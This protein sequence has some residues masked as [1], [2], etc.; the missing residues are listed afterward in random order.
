M[1]DRESRGA[2]IRIRKGQGS[3]QL[4]RDSFRERFRARFFD[5]AFDAAGPEIDRLEEIAWDAYDSSRKAPR[6]RAAGP[7]FADPTY[8][9]SDEWRSAREAI[10]R[11]AREQADP[12]SASRVLVICGSDR[13]DQTCPGEMSKTYRLA[14]TVCETIE[15]EAGFEVDM[16]DLS[17]VTSE[18]G[19]VIYP[20]KGCVST[21]M[22]LCHWPCSCYPNH[23]LGQVNDWMYELYPR[24][25]RAHGIVIVTPVY[26]YGPPSALKLLIDRLVC[27]DGGNPDPTS[28]GGK[29]PARAKALELEGWSYPRHLAG[30]VF[31]VVVHGD[32]AGAETVRRG[33]CDWL[34]DMH[35]VDAG[36]NA[37]LDRYVGYQEPYATSHEALDSDADLHE[38]VR[39][40]G[41]AVVAAALAQRSGHALDPTGDIDS[42]RPK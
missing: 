17:R 30:R 34:T 2:P 6:A 13:S 15:A 29:D 24:V 3:V 5:P 9:L 37:I 39:N 16:L 28:T 42:P 22:P 26:W 1:S 21:A 33:L 35:L 25:V 18:Y 11:A 40:V 31:G 4:D 27:A 23:A 12:A 20:C 10:E 41:R 38:E 14:R 7:G 8:E 36:R 19:R 32:Y